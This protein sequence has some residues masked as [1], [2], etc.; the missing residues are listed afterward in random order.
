MYAYK[1]Y[2]KCLTE[3][4]QRIPIS[5]PVLPGLDYACAVLCEAVSKKGEE[6]DRLV[7]SV[8]YTIDPDFSTDTYMVALPDTNNNGNSKVNAVVVF[9]GTKLSSTSNLKENY[10]IV[11]QK[12]TVSP[13]F[14]GAVKLTED[15]VKK[16]GIGNIL[17]TGF[18]LGGARALFVSE[19]VHI[20]AI[21]FNAAWSPFNILNQN[22]LNNNTYTCS[23]PSPKVRAHIIAGDYISNSLL[24]HKSCTVKK[25]L[26]LKTKYT[27]HM[28]N[29]F[30][31]MKREERKANVSKRNN[32]TKNKN[33][34]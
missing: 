12:H 31:A 20:P 25:I 4:L 16:Y 6:R 8:K 7:R 26:Y 10:L 22:I 19:S 2:K 33:N 3:S 27:T 5:P 23:D 14:V 34:K 32:N 18:S 28:L 21:V 30:L 29:N 1:K 15:I 24:C 11:R 9:R 13:L 17:L